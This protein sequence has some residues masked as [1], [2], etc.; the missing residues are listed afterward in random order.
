MI[1]YEWRVILWLQKFLILIQNLKI[2]LKQPKFHIREKEIKCIIFYGVVRFSFYLY[3]FVLLILLI[4]GL[5]YV[6]LLS[7][8]YGLFI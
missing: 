8:Q 4:G 7:V 3:Y 2:A 6:A 1:Y 5:L